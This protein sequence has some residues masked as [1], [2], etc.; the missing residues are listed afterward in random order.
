MCT[1]F[2]NLLS[3]AF[4]NDLQR[5]LNSVAQWLVHRQTFPC[6]HHDVQLTGEWPLR[7]KLA[8]VS[9][10]SADM[11]NSAIYFLGVDKWVVSW[12]QALADMVMYASNTMWSISERV[13]V[14]REGALYKSTLPLPLLFKSASDSSP[15]YFINQMFIL[16]IVLW[17]CDSAVFHMWSY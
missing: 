15:W 5:K 7:G 13:W 16:L 6:L 4:I 8:A 3:V 11:A 2:D 1:Y 9:C 10:M 14:V 12:T 17:P